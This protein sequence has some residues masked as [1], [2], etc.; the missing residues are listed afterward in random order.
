MTKITKPC[1]NLP[2]M[3]LDLK[4]K[5]LKLKTCKEDPLYLYKIKNCNR[6]GQVVLER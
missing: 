5:T 3:F 6:I 4:V 1:E 2:D